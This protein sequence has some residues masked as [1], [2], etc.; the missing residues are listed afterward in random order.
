M[1]NHVC[2]GTEFAPSVVEQENRKLA[3][4]AAAEGFVLLENK[5]ILPLTGNEVALYG[6]GA[7]MTV[8][9]GTGSGEVRNRDSVSIDLGFKNAGIKVLSEKWL[10]RFDT[11]YADT[12]EAYRQEMEKKV[13]GLRDF[14][15]I[16]RTVVPFEH[17]S[18]MPITEEDIIPGVPAIYVIA[19]QAGEG[20]D[21]DLRPGDFLLTDVEIENLRFLKA[22]TE[23]L[24]VVI[25]VG[26]VI[27][28]SI[29]DEIDPD[30]IVFMG[31][32]GE[33]GGNALADLMTGKK[34][35]SGKLTTSWPKKYED[36]PSAGNY[37][38]FSSDIHT[39]DYNEG[40]Y[41]GYRYY[42]SF[43]VEP[44]YPFGFGLSYTSFA[45]E[46]RDVRVSK[47]GIEVD[48]CVTNEG[49]TAGKEVAQVYVSVPFG[50]GR[51][52]QRLAAFG[53]T[54]T[55]EPKEQQTMTLQIPF[56]RL[57]CYDEKT[58]AWIIPAGQYEVLV[59]D[60]SR[61]TTLAAGLTLSETT[62]MEQC[63][64]IC[65]L[66]HTLKELQ[67]PVRE[68]NKLDGVKILCMDGLFPETIVH[69]YET[70]SVEI[71]PLV[72]SMT[73]EQLIH[74]VVGAGTSNNKVQVLAMGASGST[75][76]KLYDELGIPNVILSDGPAGLNL[77]SH[78]VEMPDGSYKAARVPEN[79]Q[80]Y[81]RYLFGFSRMA[82]T[83]QMAKPE[84]GI[85]HYQFTTAWPCAQ[86]LA[87][88]FNTEIV[89]KVGDGAGKEM[90]VYGVTVWLA[91]G[92]NI[93]RNPLCGRTF[94]Y[95]SEDPLVSGKMA[96]AIVR[97][98]QSHPGKFMS[99]KHFAANSC[100]LQRN[101]SSSNV[102]ERALRELYLTGFEIAVKESDP[103]T[104]MAAYNKV[105]EVYCT[106]NYDLLAKVLRC[107]WNYKGMVMSDWDSMK[108]DRNNPVVPLTGDV[109]KAPAA[110]CDLICP[111]R[112][113]QIEALK[114]AV[115][116]GKVLRSD[117]ERNATRVLAMVRKNTVLKSR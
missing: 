56:T 51:E 44:L 100:E 42:D 68:E 13:E 108:A 69:T 98:V 28:L 90:E 95:Y 81:R 75:T 29:M 7:R 14:H 78:I 17:P 114:K 85:M 33:E 97:G 113:D 60:H 22:K 96:A 77:T 27:D 87:Q 48:V 11:F 66:P 71:D 74:M 115:E 67:P 101:A 91:P 111:G 10:D 40:I 23:K 89:E 24:I 79:L 107:E 58:A 12:Y 103:G 46:T 9:G 50:E 21:R 80:A 88:S 53:K 70:P 38:Q 112:P 6:S 72:A 26:G 8:K 61:S 35:F 92:M 86:V 83:S 43:G 34:N 32:G 76:E 63:T 2:A 52:K 109:Q 93:H 54:K 15:M 57:Y 82:L 39:Q 37:S 105:N 49:D 3:N 94:E 116:E 117:L 110:Q 47:A 5:G 30:A 19:R 99:V 73:D 20:H 84:D 31:Q 18:G 64:N 16:L 36:V 45:M 102:S 4:I 104:V 59:G 25:N 55:L 65:P 62:V 106:N 41:V 1:K